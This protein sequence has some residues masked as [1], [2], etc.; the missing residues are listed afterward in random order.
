DLEHID[1]V[2]SLAKLNQGLIVYTL[3]KPDMRA[4]IKEQSEK[5]ELYAFDIIGPL[6]DKYQSSYQ[7]EPLFEPGTVRKLDDDYFKKVE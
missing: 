6:M 3:V 7:K 4:Y 1:E 5:E 2:I